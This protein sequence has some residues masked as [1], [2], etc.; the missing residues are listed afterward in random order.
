MTLPELQLQH[1]LLAVLA[2]IAMGISKAGFSG[3]SLLHVLIFAFIFGARDSTGIVLPMLVAA[4]VL[5]VRAFR[6]HA[7]WDYVRRMLPATAIGVALGFV[8]M[9]R[10]D[11][12]AFK[13]LVG[14]IILAFTALHVLRTVR[15]TWFSDDVPHSRP[16][17]WTIGLIAGVTTMLANAAGPIFTIYALAVALPKFELVATT[18][19]FF[20]IVNLIKV[21]F[22][23][24]LGLITAD[25]L[26]LNA[27]LV[28]AVFVG[29]AAGR[30]LTRRVPQQ[31]FNAILLMF[32]AIGALRLVGA[33]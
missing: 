17:A 19:W 4:D 25:T 13:R 15:P 27:A 28:P 1:W 26:V 33:W 22:S 9:G 11:D 24:R 23:A 10:I 18:A 14:G 16:F 12:E 29:I 2:A 30:W 5:A 31:Q 3:M 21:P 20:L 32:A 8:L 7:R 6:E